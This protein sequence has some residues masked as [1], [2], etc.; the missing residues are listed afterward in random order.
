MRLPKLVASLKAKLAK[1]G[2][3]AD[4]W[5]GVFVGFSPAAA[6]RNYEQN[7]NWDLGC[8]FLRS[9]RLCYWGEETKFSLRLDQITAITVAPGMP[10]LLPPRRIYMAWKD[11]EL[12]T[13]GVFNIGCINGASTLRLRKQSSKLAERLKVWWKST[14]T[15]RPVPGPLATLRSPQIGAVTGAV[16]RFN[17]GK[18]FTE[19]F[20]TAIF[21]IVGAIL[22]S[23]PFQLTA[24]L[25]SRLNESLGRITAIHS[26]GSGW[27]V[28]A[29]VLLVRFFA[30]IPAL[31]YKDQAIVTIAP[32]RAQTSQ[33][34]AT[35]G[36]QAQP[37]KVEN[38]KVFSH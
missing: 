28:V 17:A 21:A 11:D 38:D 10:G 26:P 12:G 4:A 32:S 13:T 33:I 5:D 16:P 20:L 24:F 15:A 3:L 25:F 8:L 35:P 34:N 31:R 2:V 1:E 7:T 6:P 30:M 22:C 36:T 37:A 29:V 14:P 18:V 23:L 9:D 27:Y 19:L